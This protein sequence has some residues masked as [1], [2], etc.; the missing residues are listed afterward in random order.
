MQCTAYQ[1]RVMRDQGMAHVSYKA[2][3]DYGYTTKGD[4]Y[5]Q[6]V[7]RQ[8]LAADL[9]DVV[10]IHEVGHIFFHHMDV[11]T[12][13]ELN[14]ISAILRSC[15]RTAAD[16]VYYGGPMTFLNICMDLEVNTKV[17]TNENLQVVSNLG[18]CS[19]QRFSLS[20]QSNF[21]GYYEPLIKAIPASF[22]GTELLKTLST[23]AATASSCDIPSLNDSSMASEVIGEAYQ[24][25]NEKHKGSDEK[26]FSAD[27]T[28][29]ND[30]IEDNKGSGKTDKTKS[31]MKGNS[32]D[33]DDTATLDPTFKAIDAIEL[34]LKEIVTTKKVS[35]LDSLRLYNRGT[36]RNTAGIM[37]TSVKKQRIHS[38]KK[39]AV[40]IDVS[41]SM[42]AS[43][44]LQALKSF[45]KYNNLIDPASIVATWNESLVESFPIAQIPD[46]VKI[47]GGTHLATAIKHFQDQNFD[48]IIIYSDFEDDLDEMALALKTIVPHFII[49]NDNPDLQSAKWH[50]T[51]TLQDV[52]HIYVKVANN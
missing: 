36:R 45:K 34:F 24:S 13:K 10:L 46:Q 26:D 40:V 44:I 47:S 20:L 31:K 41:G 2:M 6:I 19:L 9:N 25:D 27:Y 5:Y 52:H 3:N 32:T 39:L 30:I 23:I 7:L 4:T 22:N 21:R 50:S 16:L 12:A 17:W 1:N 48:D 42:N 37:Y 8:G 35:A 18:V 14:D 51:K 43:S 11:D 28:T 33:A 38:K 15:G 29:A 49:V